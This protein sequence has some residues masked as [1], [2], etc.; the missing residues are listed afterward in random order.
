MAKLFYICASMLTVSSI[1]F[2]STEKTCATREA[3]I[4]VIVDGTPSFNYSIADRFE[5]IL[6]VKYHNVDAPMITENPAPKLQSNFNRLV[7]FPELGS[8]DQQKGFAGG[9]R[10]PPKR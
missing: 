6:D 9:I 7:V 5:K 4:I 1:A 8:G 2:A 3:T 10:G